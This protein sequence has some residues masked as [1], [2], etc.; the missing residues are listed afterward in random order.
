MSTLLFIFGRTHELSFHELQA[1]T[2]YPLTRITPDVVRVE[3]P[4]NEIDPEEYM[5]RFGGTVKIAR[6]KGTIGSLDPVSIAQHLVDVG[7]GPV[8]FGLSFYGADMGDVD[9]QL[10]KGMKE[11][12]ASKGMSSRYVAPHEGHTLS[13]VVIA[14]QHIHE[15]VI[16]SV[17]GGYLVG[18][19]LAV[20]DF[21]SWNERDYGRP[22]AD[23][24]AGM[25]PPKVARM[26]VNLAMAK[27]K[28]QKEKGVGIL[29]DPFCG[30]GTVVGEAILAGWTAIGSDQSEEAVDKAKKNL[31][32]LVGLTG[33]RPVM[34]QGETPSNLKLFV[35]DA[36][37]ISDVLPNSSVDAIVTEPFMGSTDINNK[38]Q[39]SSF[40]IDD[41]KNTLKGLE[42]L[43]IGCLR[44]WYTVLKPEGKIVIA[45]PQY[46]I[47]G[48]TYFVKNVIDRCETLGYTVSA[49]PLPYSRPQ[50]VVR[51]QFYVLQKGTIS[52]KQ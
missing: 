37:H 8:T 34:K 24:K 11:H 25:L 46:T 50:A 33:S 42:K 36:T 4:E 39:Q 32:W 18:E 21:E 27:G 9:P 7:G 49:G 41:I 2:S 35:S 52:N 17:G 47:S 10:L 38:I 5:K 13:S 20:Q 29:L 26:A 48:R 40:I 3:D 14:K 45:L 1:L 30:M 51:R 22:Y 44:D 19:T 23:P 12:L 31:D 28:R 15:L 16:I 6:E 43:Y